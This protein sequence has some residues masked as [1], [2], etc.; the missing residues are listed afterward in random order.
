MTEIK[1]RLGSIGRT[2]LEHWRR[3][4]HSDAST[5]RLSLFRI[6]FAY[7]LWK[8]IPSTYNK[9]G[10]ALEGGFHLPYTALIQ[11]VSQET[12]DWIHLIQYPIILAFGLGFYSRLCSGI[13]LCLQG[14]IYFA[15]QMNFRNHPLFFMLI[16]VAFCMAPG[17][18]S[19]S[20]RT[21]FRMA[22]TG[23]WSWSGMLGGARSMTAQRLIQVQVSIAYF[24]AGIHKCNGWFLSG[25]QLEKSLTKNQANWG[26]EMDELWIPENWVEQFAEFLLD[27]TVLVV[28]ACGAVIFE[29]LAGFMLWHR[30]LRWPTFVMG[31]VFHY[32]IFLF[33]NIHTF[34]YAIVASYILFLPIDFWQT[35]WG[36]M[37][38]RLMVKY[39]KP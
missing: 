24:V 11:P 31:L 13:L 28:G 8:E 1:I 36:W 19:L 26:E 38:T 18:E 21:A 39:P 37:R 35:A 14:Y 32:S 25:G 15:D 7:C 16:L 17:D 6:C 5:W 12:Y 29:L 27:P 22:T 23:R 34:S 9:S 3:F 10:F 4:W 30:V 33:M 2:G 20:L